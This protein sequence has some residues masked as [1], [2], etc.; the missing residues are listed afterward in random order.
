MVHYI[1]IHLQP[2]YQKL[3]FRTGLFKEAEKYA[4]DAITLPLHPWLTDEQQSY[5]IKSFNVLINSN[6]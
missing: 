6:K 2:Y 3:G 5:I 4:K 1:P